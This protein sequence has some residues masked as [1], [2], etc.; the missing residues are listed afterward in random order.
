MPD[1]LQ[2]AGDFAK[3]L[4]LGRSPETPKY[5]YVNPTYPTWHEKYGQPVPGFNP[6]TGSLAPAS[7]SPLDATTL[8]FRRNMVY[9]QPGMQ[10]Y[11]GY[12]PYIDEMV[13]KEKTGPYSWERPNR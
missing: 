5:G 3:R 4:L 9:D 10:M 6:R 2:F 8:E 1:A 13:E 7:L 12:N 11:P